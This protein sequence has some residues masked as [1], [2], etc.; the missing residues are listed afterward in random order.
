MY[1][2]TFLQLKYL[3]LEYFKLTPS[4][5]KKWLDIYRPGLDPNGIPKVYQNIKNRKK[6]GFQGGTSV[7]LK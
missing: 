5:Y 7:F 6:N 3:F 4:H 2:Q 1:R